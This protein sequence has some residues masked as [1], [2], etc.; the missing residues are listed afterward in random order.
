[1]I[2]LHSICGTN[3]VS[4]DNIRYNGPHNSSHNGIS[5]SKNYLIKERLKLKVY[6]HCICFLQCLLAVPSKCSVQMNTTGVIIKKY[7]TTLTDIQQSNHT[8]KRDLKKLKFQ[9]CV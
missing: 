4:F 3:V 1:M 5:H 7:C 2:Y 8:V 6:A 9:V